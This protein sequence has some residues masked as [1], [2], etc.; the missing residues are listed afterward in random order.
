MKEKRKRSSSIWRRL[1]LRYLIILLPYI[2]FAYS[3]L[4]RPPQ[5]Y[6]N[7]NGNDVLY[8]HSGRLLMKYDPHTQT[9]QEIMPSPTDFSISKNGKIAYLTKYNELVLAHLDESH[10]LIAIVPTQSDTVRLLSL[11]PDGKYL[12]YTDYDDSG[13]ARILVWNGTTSID[14]TPENSYV[15][16]NFYLSWE[17]ANQIV[18]NDNNGFVFMASFAD[19]ILPTEIYYWDTE[20]TY[21]LSQNPE[22]R[23]GIIG[24]SPDGQFA[25]WST[26]GE[27]Y[28]AQIKLWDGHS[29]TDGTPHITT[30]DNTLPILANFDFAT[31][32]PDN[33]LIFH[34]SDYHLLR[35][36]GSQIQ[37]IAMDD[38][39]KGSRPTFN[40]HGD[41]AFSEW[42]SDSIYVADKHNRHVQTIRGHMQTWSEDGYL[43]FCYPHSNALLLYDGTDII[44]VNENASHAQFAQWQSGQAL[45]C[46][47]G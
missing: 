13:K 12:A 19:N 24:W 31:W 28:N 37:H 41:W 10:T 25:F 9:H 22:G 18:W 42:W 29:F 35:W 8:Y 43:A 26:V 7:T 14:I 30:I 6:I 16:V 15:L 2:V 1:K 3:I 5:I 45:G 38:D 27:S 47:N 36:D 23:D 39:P 33:H 20:Q 34:Q 46:H 32:T 11:S 21:N 44:T 17:F 40:S 4:N